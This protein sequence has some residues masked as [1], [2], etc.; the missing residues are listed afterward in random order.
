[1]YSSS[2]KHRPATVSAF[3]DAYAKEAFLKRSASS[4][5]RYGC[6]PYSE[7]VCK[8]TQD[9]NEKENE[10]E[11]Q[12]LCQ[13]KAEHKEKSPF[14]PCKPNENSGLLSGM[15][16]GDILLVLLI[17]FFLVDSD[18]EH[19]ILIPILLSLVLLF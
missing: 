4:D 6:T 14:L 2:Y 7:K 13:S 3:E 8:K 17:I 16:G 15:D 1:M 19:D 10:R 5:N 12:K 11:T 9:C 18:N